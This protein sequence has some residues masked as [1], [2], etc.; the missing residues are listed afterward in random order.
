MCDI[1]YAMNT[2]NESGKYSIKLRWGDF[3]LSTASDK[4]INGLCEWY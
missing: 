1:Y 3:E 4:S 2:P